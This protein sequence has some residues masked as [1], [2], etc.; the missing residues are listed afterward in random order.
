M[1]MVVLGLLI[2]GLIA[3]LALGWIAPL[4]T[5]IVRLRRGKGGKVLIGIGAAW[6][7]VLVGMVGFAARTYFVYQ[8]RYSV[9][10]F[11]PAKFKG[12]T[13]T[14][15]LPY[16]G[17]GT[18]RFE[19]ALQ[20]ADAEKRWSVTASNGVVVVPAG[21]LTVSYLNVSLA[22][23]KGETLGW[24][25]GSIAPENVTFTLEPNGRHKIPGGFPLTASVAAE[26][27]GDQ[28]SLDFKMVDTA[29]N[30][31]AWNAAG[32]D[33]KPPAFEAVSPDGK[34][35]WRDDFEYG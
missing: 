24:L 8:Q 34:S 9:A 5:G 6:F 4:I 27:R 26:K 22:G 3:L 23:D 7:L 21:K 29:G 2:W 30:K 17:A 15:E 14:V 12:E 1:S 13:G 31:V 19:Q 25:S 32:A 28:L 20:G 33:R 35:F 16:P 11:N 10:E 18:L